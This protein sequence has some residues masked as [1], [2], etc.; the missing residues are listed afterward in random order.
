[1]YVYM[2]ES[3]LVCMY[4]H[5]YVCMYICMYEDLKV[6][7]MKEREYKEV[8]LELWTICTYSTIET[9][10]IMYVCMYVCLELNLRLGRA[11]L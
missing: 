10:I 3:G 11:S 7:H 9:I 1:M 6:S 8:I 5:I 4:V 2:Y